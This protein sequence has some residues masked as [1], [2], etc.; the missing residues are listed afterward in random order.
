VSASKLHPNRVE[1]NAQVESLF[2]SADVDSETSSDND[3]IDSSSFVD[4]GL[5][6]P[7]AYDLDII[8]AM[9]QDPYRVFVYWDIRQQSI[10]G[11]TYFASSDDPPDFQT[12]LKLIDI[13]DGSESF[14]NVERQGS[15]W[16]NVSPGREYEFEIGVHTTEHGYRSLMRS[17]RVH[18]PNTEVS[19]L[20]ADRADYRVDPEEFAEVLEASGFS[21]ALA[22]QQQPEDQRALQLSEHLM[23]P[24]F[25]GRSSA[26]VHVGGSS[27]LE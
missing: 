13:S 7:E 3:E 14:I 26:R 23:K 6:I 15:H 20:M 27:R 24:I 25:S 17:N 11:I 22:S 18:A 1:T 9:V 19:S 12:T 4:S 21:A 2:S 5:P 10:D 16:I 8:R